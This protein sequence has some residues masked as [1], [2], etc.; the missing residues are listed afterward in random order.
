MKKIQDTYD[1]YIRMSPGKPTINQLM[2]KSLEN[3]KK[4]EEKKKAA[5]SGTLLTQTAE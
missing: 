4:L 1:N 5:E 3:E 2:N